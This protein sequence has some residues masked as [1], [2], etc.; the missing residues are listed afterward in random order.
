MAAYWF[1]AGVQYWFP[2][3]MMK[4]CAL[5]WQRK[6]STT[7][8]CSSWSQSVQESLHSGIA[9]FA[10]L[11]FL[12]WPQVALN[13]PLQSWLLFPLSFP[14]ACWSLEWNGCCFWKAFWKLSFPRK[15]EESVS[16]SQKSRA[17]CLLVLASPGLVPWGNALQGVQLS[18]DYNSTGSASCFSMHYLS[19]FYCT[20]EHHLPP[21]LFC[22]GVQEVKEKCLPVL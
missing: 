6:E 11:S 9:P 16:L 19:S 17:V 13:H 18:S 1:M 2:M 8:Q 22:T 5:V 21:S 7:R 10:N 4:S 14:S 20:G 12:K 3:N 15:K